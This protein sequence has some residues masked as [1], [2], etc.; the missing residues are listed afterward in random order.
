VSEPAVTYSESDFD[1][2]SWHDCRIW[3]FQLLTGDPSE[4]D[5]RAE[6]ALDIDFITT[7]KCGI[8]KRI[9]VEIA[10]A[11][12]VFR[13]VSALKIQLDWTETIT[14]GQEI[15]VDALERIRVEDQ[16]DT[17]YYSWKFRLHAPAGAIVFRAAGFT[18]TL[19][20]TPIESHTCSLS[21]GQRSRLPRR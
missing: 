4:S 12:L 20:A 6:L 1:D 5:W 10:P 11:A 14:W 3:G 17:P 7:W 13:D 18:Q 15:S 9:T 8:D 19:L 2:L 21:L 16:G